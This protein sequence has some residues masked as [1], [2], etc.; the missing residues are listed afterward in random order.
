M[1]VKVHILPLPFG[2]S[3]LANHLLYGYQTYRH[4]HCP[5]ALQITHKQI[6]T[7]FAMSDKNEHVKNPAKEEEE[8]P[9]QQGELLSPPFTIFPQ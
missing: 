8:E 7:V 6:D 3:L 9:Q 5:V 4:Y 2:A 1:N